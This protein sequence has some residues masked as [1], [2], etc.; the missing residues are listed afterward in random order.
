MATGRPAV[1][2]RSTGG[3][4]GWRCI[5]GRRAIFDRAEDASG[6]QDSAALA[7]N[8][9]ERSGNQGTFVMGLGDK[10]DQTKGHAMTAGTFMRMS[11]GVR[12]FEWTKGE[13]IVH[14]YGSGPLDT[15][16]VNPADDPTRKSP[17]K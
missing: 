10:F 15:I 8:G 3:G 7:P 2:C 11:K 16:Y 13:T 1:A 4:V 5:K 17:T 14:V 12:H 6:L 9:R